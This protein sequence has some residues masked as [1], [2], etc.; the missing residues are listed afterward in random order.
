MFYEVEVQVFCNAST[1]ADGGVA[2]LSV[3]SSD[4]VIKVGFVFGKARRA[5]DP[6]MTIP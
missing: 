3:T 2:H 1:E 4:R 5:P 6:D